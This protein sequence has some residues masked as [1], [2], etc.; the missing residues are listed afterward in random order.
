[1]VTV[2]PHASA[3]T[4]SFCRDRA[5]GPRV[6]LPSNAKA[7]PWHGQSKPLPEKVTVQHW[8]VQDAETATN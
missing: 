5:A 3:Q 6:T 2:T 7:E 8:C 4:A 1:M